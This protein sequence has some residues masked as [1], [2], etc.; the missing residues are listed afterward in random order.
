MNVDFASADIAPC[1]PDILEALVAAVVASDSQKLD[2]L[3]EKAYENLSATSLYCWRRLHTEASIFSALV[4]DPLDAI[5]KLD[6]A[7]IISGA[8]GEGRL[9]L[10]LSIIQRVQSEQF[11]LRSFTTPSLSQDPDAPVI[12]PGPAIPC[13]STPPSLSAFQSREYQAPFILRAYARSWPALRERPWA[14]TEYLRAVAGPGRIVPVEVGRDYRTDDWSQKLMSWDA[15]LAS[16]DSDSG[17]ILYLAQHSLL[18]QFPAL[19][20]D[21][22]V[23]DY[24]YAVLPRPPGCEPPENDEQLVLNAWLGPKGTVSPAHTDPYYNIYVQVAGRKTVWMAPPSCGESMR[25]KGNTSTIDVF[26]TD[27]PGGMLASL[28]AG[29]LLYMP[30]GWWHAMRADCRSF[31][32]SMWF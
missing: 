1:G 22:E 15:F 30:V 19:R 16:L 5:A 31:S 6:A 2:H 8:A 32:V 14:S 23:P 3:I 12:F 26:A 27:Q 28:D 4:S 20:A 7:I 18:M 21:I 29:D 25:A 10:I 11:P 9:D 13:L 17:E 24:V